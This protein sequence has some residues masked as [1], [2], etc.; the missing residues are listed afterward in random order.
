[1]HFQ[2]KIALVSPHW[3]QLRSNWNFNTVY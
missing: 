2:T 3:K 1:M